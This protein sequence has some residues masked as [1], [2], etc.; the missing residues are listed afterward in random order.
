MRLK[1]SESWLKS[2]LGKEK[3]L[4]RRYRIYYNKIKNINKIFY[5]HKRCGIPM[6]QATIGI[7]YDKIEI[8]LKQ[9]DAIWFVMIYDELAPENFNRHTISSLSPLG[10]DE[11]GVYVAF[12]IE[13]I[14]RLPDLRET[15][16]KRKKK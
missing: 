15:L 1:V 7:C 9:M 8:C 6:H 14:S 4:Y 3:R 2:N 12:Y 13:K 11:N 10:Q 16:Q 5:H